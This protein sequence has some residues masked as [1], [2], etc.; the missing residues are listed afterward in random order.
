MDDLR[1]SQAVLDVAVV[2]RLAVIA[3][4]GAGSLVAGSSVAFVD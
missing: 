1:V 4:V 3:F 2:S